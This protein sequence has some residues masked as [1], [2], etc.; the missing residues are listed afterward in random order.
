MADQQPPKPSE[1]GESPLND[2]TMAIATEFST[3]L[4][5]RP[6][7]VAS[8]RN[9]WLDATSLQRAPKGVAVVG[10]IGDQAIR[11][12]SRPARS[13][14]ARHGNGGESL[15]EERDLR[16]G[17]RVQVCSHRSTRA[18][19]QKHPL[20]TLASLRFA[21]LEPPFFA[22][23]KLPSAKHSSQRSFSRSFRFARK[24]RHI[25]SSVPSTSQAWSRRQQVVGLPY[26]RGS[27]LHGDPVQRIQRIPSKHFR[28]SAR[29][30]P[31]RGLGEW[32]GRCL[33]VG[34][35]P[36]CHREP[37]KERTWRYG[38]PSD[39]VLE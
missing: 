3:I 19:D 39:Q 28:S 24:A 17:R 33:H 27:S 15:L 22:G 10:P 1:P 9:D 7:V 20:R 29:G 36:P 8:C 23:A 11:V 5:G 32:I 34:Q 2:P 21:D 31:P 16:R 18:I 6:K 4:V 30:R 35:P 13:M 26:R 37:P 14:R 12:A 25:A 38:T